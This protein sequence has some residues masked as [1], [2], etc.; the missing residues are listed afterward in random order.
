MLTI[1]MASLLAAASDPVPV[2]AASLD[3]QPVRHCR[4]LMIGIS[5]S[6]DV[7]I[8]RSKTQWKKWDSC[9]GAT[10]FCSQAEKASLG[11]YTAFPLTE[12]S[13]IVC[14][15]LKATGSRLSAQRTCLPQREWQRMWDNSS[16]TMSGLQNKHSNRPREG[17]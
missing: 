4:P 11:G 10:R 9:T 5:R 15:V 7:Y 6:E 1:V 17:Q 3:N 13:R 8:C 16:E 14:R 2:E 12:D